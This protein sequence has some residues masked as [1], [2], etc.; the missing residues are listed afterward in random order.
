MAQTSNSII[1]SSINIPTTASLGMTRMRIIMKWNSTP[2][3]PCGTIT[4]GEVED[5]SINIGNDLSCDVGTP[6]DD[7]D[8]CTINDN[9]DNNCNCIG[10]FQDTDSDGICDSNDN[11]NGNCTLGEICNDGDSCTINDNF[12][13]NCNCIGTFQDTDNDG[14]CNADDPCPNDPNNNCNTVDYCTAQGINTNYEFIQRVQFGSIDNNSGDNDGYADFTNLSTNVSI[15]QNMN[16]LLTPGFYGS[17]YSEHF[18]IW[19]DFNQDGDFS[20]TGEQVFS[21]S[22]S[23]II[24]GTINIPNN[25]LVGTTRMR[26]AM[27]WSSPPANA[28][29]NYSYGEVED[30]SVNIISQNNFSAPIISD[31]SEAKSIE[32]INV[33][34]F[35]NPATHTLN[36]TWNQSFE[37]GHLSIFNSNGIVVYQQAIANDNKQILLNLE[38]LSEGIYF[39]RLQRNNNKIITT[40][41]FIKL[42]Q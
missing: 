20:D 9:L 33:K 7:N 27:R 16:I 31:V 2:A 8:P 30:Y 6:C 36:I 5:Y 24:N 26:I 34:L 40:Q 11:T 15:G 21:Q 25:A 1:T 13:A 41:R 42:A 32:N 3:S 23:T 28:C 35:P 22:S 14:I 18:R 37:N 12:D 4:Y 19:I 39:A 38:G 29:G 17:S 10:T